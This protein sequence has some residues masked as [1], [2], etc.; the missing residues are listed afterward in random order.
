MSK[1]A[2]V[3][4]DDPILC[5]L[6]T[7]ALKT[8]GIEV[9]SASTGEEGLRRFYAGRPDVVVLDVRMP[10]MDGF[11]TLRQIRRL[12]E[13][14]V[15]M[16][17]SESDESDVVRGLDLGADEYVAKPCPTR[18]LVA[19]VQAALRRTPCGAAVSPVPGYAD[20]YLTVDLLDRRVT[21][22]G[23]PVKLSAK[24]YGMLAYLVENAGRILTAGQILQHVWGWEYQDD[25]DYVRVYMAH[26]RGKLEEDPKNPQYL[27]TEHG[28]G[29]RFVK[30]SRN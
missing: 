1:K 11:E 5:R 30:P 22:R 26:L 29:Y 4:D 6:A 16:L 13:V 27:L 7:A 14:P 20:D 2:L 15:V 24:E 21:V 8:A 17:T 12:S 10:G 23:Q 9:D 25:V 19:R 18:V 3:I 28:V